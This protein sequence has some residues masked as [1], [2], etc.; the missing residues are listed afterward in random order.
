M[1][2]SRLYIAIR[3]EVPDYIV[4]TLVAH[5]ILN[6]DEE[7]GFDPLWEGWRSQ[8]FKKCVVRVNQK[9]WDKIV[10]L[11]RVYQ[12][13]EKHTLNGEMSCAIVLPCENEHLPSVL[14]FAKLWKPREGL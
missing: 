13:Y 2:D 7:F 14:K 5:T 4:P 12:G 6:A 1:K 9:E 11:P 3:D 8:S 10:S